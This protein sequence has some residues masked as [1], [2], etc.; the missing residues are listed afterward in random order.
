MQNVKTPAM[1]A[2]A[3]KLRA[4]LRELNLSPG[5][6]GFG[7]KGFRARVVQDLGG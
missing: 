3:D 6:Q 4:T 7:V 1:A 5:G 2:P